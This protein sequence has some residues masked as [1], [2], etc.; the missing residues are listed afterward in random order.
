[1]ISV[2]ILAIVSLIFICIYKLDINNFFS[3]FNKYFIRENKE[4]ITTSKLTLI[5]LAGSEK[6]ANIS[7]SK[8][9]YYDY[10]LI[11]Q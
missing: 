3:L 8:G 9:D 11:A 1:M 4:Q 5:D 10:L 2:F 7:D 6:V